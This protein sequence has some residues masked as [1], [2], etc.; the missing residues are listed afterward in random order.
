LPAHRCRRV[1]NGQQREGRRF[2]GKENAGLYR[3][4]LKMQVSTSIHSVFATP[5][6]V[7]GQSISKARWDAQQ[8]AHLAAQWLA[9]LIAVSPSVKMASETFDVSA[10]LIRRARAKIDDN[11][12]VDE[13]IVLTPDQ[14]AA[15]A[16]TLGE[17]QIWHILK[18]AAGEE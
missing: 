11:E 9:G 1:F 18:L 4:E 13:Q 12:V 16:R 2:P 10:P 6:I 5:V 15:L 17:E 14:C 3:K 7:T 8:R